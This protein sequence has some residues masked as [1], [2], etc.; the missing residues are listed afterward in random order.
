MIFKTDWLIRAHGAVVV[1]Q[2]SVRMIWN[3]C[4]HSL[5]TCIFCWCLDSCD[6]L[7][8]KF[9]HHF[10]FHFNQ[11]RMV[12][13]I[14][15]M[16]CMCLALW[17]LCGILL[18]INAFLTWWL[19]FST[20]F[21]ASTLPLM[22]AT[23][24]QFKTFSSCYLCQYMQSSPQQMENHTAKYMKKSQEQ[25]R[26]IKKPQILFQTNAEAVFAKFFSIIT[27]Q[28]V[29]AYQASWMVSCS[30]TVLYKQD[31]FLLFPIIRTSFLL[32]N[33]SKSSILDRGFLHL[34]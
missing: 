18:L 2:S 26:N 27:S 20:I 33:T 15:I 22:L 6:R 21:D 31:H 7:V 32:W 12:P 4:Q 14:N 34:D 11:N 13:F 25:F 23:S 24:T 10:F 17:L 19:Y 29:I 9:L 30:R 5:Q 3:L 8:F 28:C 16:A 1:V